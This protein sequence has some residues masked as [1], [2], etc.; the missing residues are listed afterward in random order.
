MSAL[1]TQGPWV[2][3]EKKNVSGILNIEILGEHGYSL[4]ANCYG[5]TTGLADWYAGARHVDANARLIAAAPCM[6]EVMKWAL[7]VVEAAK[8]VDDD[9]DLVIE[10]YRAAIAKAT[11][12]TI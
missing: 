7:P 12:E 5:T 8:G 3:G 11:G 6:L 2:V 4:V 10:D 1:H 9:F